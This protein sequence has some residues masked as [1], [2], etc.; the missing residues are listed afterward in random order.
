[1][2]FRGALRRGNSRIALGGKK[3]LGGEKVPRFGGGS[4]QTEAVGKKGVLD[5]GKILNAEQGAAMPGHSRGGRMK[6]R[7][8][9]KAGTI[10]RTFP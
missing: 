5:P 10:E 2:S 3:K 9:K 7:K 1:V 4:L 6:S 8:I